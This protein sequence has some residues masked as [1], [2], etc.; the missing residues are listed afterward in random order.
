MPRTYYVYILS[1]RRRTVLYTG[2]TN[3]LRR[4]LAEHALHQPGT[5][6][7]TYQVTELVHC[8]LFDMP[9]EAIAREKQI[10]GWRREKKLA[11][12]LRTNPEMVDLKQTVLDE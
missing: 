8:E 11:L 2:M 9:S 5:F 1:N 12:I 6:T 4:R 3:D 10:K 7:A